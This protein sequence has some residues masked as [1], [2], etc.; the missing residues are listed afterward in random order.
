MTTPYRMSP[1]RLVEPMLAHKKPKLYT[2]QQYLEEIL[3]KHPYYLAQPKIDGIRCLMHNGFPLSRKFLGI[4]NR[5]IAKTMVVAC[6]ENGLDGELVT[7][8]NG[9]RDDFNTIQSKVMSQDGA[10][11]FKYLIFDYAA[12]GYLDAPFGVRYMDMLPRITLPPFCKTFHDNM[13]IIESMSQLVEVEKLFIEEQKW[14]GVMLRVPDARYKCGRSTLNEGFLVALK[15]F[16]DSEA[17]VTGY[18]EQMHN[19]NAYGTDNFGRSKRS[20][21]KEGMVK[22]GMLG[23]F[24]VKDCVTGVEFEVSTGLNKAQRIMYWAKRNSL[25][26]HILTYQYQAYGQKDKPRCP[27]FKGWRKE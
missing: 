20:K 12:P 1:R 10:P 23:G 22:S 4:P 3:L 27:S 24:K 13:H 25:I 15:T 2:R 14:E 9:I 16:E 21:A 17:I 8:T 7:Y 19:D 6:L 18:F 26:G 11:D 5:H